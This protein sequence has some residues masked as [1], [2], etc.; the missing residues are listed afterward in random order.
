MNKLLLGA[1]A[2]L[3]I[4]A[5]AAAQEW[6]YQSYLPGGSTPSAP[7]YFKLTETSPGNFIGR[8]MFPGQDVC[9]RTD[10]PAKV[11]HEGGLQLVTLEPRLPGCP[12]IRLA[13]KADGSG[14]ERQLLQP[15][16]T[17]AFDGMQRGLVRR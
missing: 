8:L 13:L 16:G 11:A 9:Y 15:D 12:R 1:V 4:G 14:G 17:W 5:S 7:G 10:M 2:A 6:S 3:G